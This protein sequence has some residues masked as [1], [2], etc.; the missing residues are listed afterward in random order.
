MWTRES[1]FVPA[2]PTAKASASPGSITPSTS[3]TPAP[4]TPA[5]PGTGPA[6][7]GKKPKKRT[8]AT[9]SVLD[10]GRDLA[11]KALDK[12]SACEKLAKEMT[13]LAFGQD[14]CR[15]NC[16]DNNAFLNVFHFQDLKT[17]LE[18]YGS[19]FQHPGLSSFAQRT[20]MIAQDFLL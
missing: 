12:S 8:V 5:T 15:F 16:T 7:N 1:D 6:D 9:L 14:S 4:G 2:R 18:G 20:C 3:P 19:Q 13:T 10:K 11:K 17:K